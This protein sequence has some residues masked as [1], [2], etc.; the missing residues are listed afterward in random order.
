MLKKSS[1][2]VLAS[3][4]GSTYRSVR[5]ASSLAAVLLEGHFEHS[6]GDSDSARGLSNSSRVRPL[7]TMMTVWLSF[8][9]IIGAAVF[10]AGAFTSLSAQNVTGQSLIEKTFPHSTKCK[11]CHERV[12]EEW[13]TSPM[14]KSIHSPAF[15]A[16]LD[17]YLNSTMGKDKT[18]CFRCHAPHVREFS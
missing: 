2:I 9:V 15:R 12:Y 3:L 13:E 17:M 18:Q 14:A 8:A 1:S 11:R 5:L 6:A 4:R 7:P 10:S 16:S